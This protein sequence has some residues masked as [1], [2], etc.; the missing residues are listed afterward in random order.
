MNLTLTKVGKFADSDT[1]SNDRNQQKYVIFPF[2]FERLTEELGTLVTNEVGEFCIIPNE[3]IDLITAEAPIPYE[4]FRKLEKI[5]VLARGEETGAY[6]L[7]SLK[8]RRKYQRLSEFTSLHM[9]V[10][11]LRCNQSCPYCQVS[12]QSEDRNTFD[13]SK[14]VAEKALQHIF[15]SP[16][17]NIKI[18]F[19]GGESLL[20]FDLIKWVVRR[21]REICPTDV[22]L[23][24]VAAT[25]LTFLTDEIIQFF[26]DE[27]ILFSTSI[28]G[29]V[30]LHNL[31]RPYRGEDAFGIVCRN[32]RRIQDN[33]GTDS[34]AALM[35]TT[36]RSLKR[37][38]EIVDQYI[39]L[40][41]RGMF[42]RSLSP[43]GFA[44]KTKTY[45]E[46]SAHQ[47]LD[48]YKEA[49]DYILEINRQG[50]YFEE[51]YTKLIVNRMLNQ[52]AD[53]YVDLQSPTG[54][55][56]MGAIYD[57]DGKVYVSD[58]ARM[59]AQMGD[60]TLQLG[61]VN[62]TY[63]DLFLRGKLPELVSSTMN[64][65]APMC[66]SCAF[67]QWCGSEPSYHQ[68]TQKDFLGHKAYSGFCHKQMGLFRHLIEL[69]TTRPEDWKTI[70]NWI[71]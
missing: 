54:S 52:S 59:L 68:S 44:L 8:L 17:M 28:D 49:L 9:M 7:L 61:H 26:G 39:A 35:T 34:V 11:T 58:E 51:F 22:N 36:A 48:F 18:E 20:N 70:I 33:L 10:V 64:Q 15:R 60:H 2:R 69:S 27:G 62:D 43:Y 12:R 67:L 31:N 63:E 32:I 16:S 1:L 30:D 19:Q 21:S 40:G 45:Y 29:P 14:E 46:Y 66:H 47:W 37:P 3:V 50:H 25:N 65:S 6:S 56:T 38:K 23:A 24:F 5:H 4:F 13:M 42:L 41:F 71:R 53:G 55:G 57:Y